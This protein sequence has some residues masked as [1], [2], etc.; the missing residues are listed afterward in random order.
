VR[1]TFRPG[2]HAYRTPAGP[3]WQPTEGQLEALGDDGRAFVA[4]VLAGYVV[5]ALEGELALE[6]A[7]AV[8]RLAEVRGQRRR[9]LSVKA[10]KG[11]D[12]RELA[13]TRVLSGC[14]LAL[15]AR[16]LQPKTAAPASK[17]GAAV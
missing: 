2:E 12:Q 16:L 14:V 13:W 6:G 15:R 11:L 5:G 17:W 8:D 4:R 7:H 3:P 10:L 1:G 9:R